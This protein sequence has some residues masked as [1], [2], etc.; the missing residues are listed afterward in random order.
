[1]IAQTVHRHAT[2]ELLVPIFTLATHRILIVRRLRIGRCARTICQD[3]SAVR[4]L[5]VRLTF[6]DNPTRLTPGSRLIPK[7]REEPLRYPGFVPQSYSEITSPPLRVQRAR[8]MSIDVFAVISRHDPSM[9]R[10]C[11]PAVCGPMNPPGLPLR[12]GTL[13]WT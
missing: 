12:L 11:V 10:N 5:Q 1:M 3:E 4:P 13:D 7:A 9:F 2:F 8:N 6:G